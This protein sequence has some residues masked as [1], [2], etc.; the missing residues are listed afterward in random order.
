MFSQTS[1]ALVI[2]SEDPLKAVSRTQNQIPKSMECIIPTQLPTQASHADI[3]D[4]IGDDIDSRAI[5]D[6][7][8]G[9][10]VV[11]DTSFEFSSVSC[12]ATNMTHV[13]RFASK[14]LT[15]SA[16]LLR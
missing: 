15:L 7:S 13:S 1:K 11:F 8:V 5:L 16:F 2:A 10:P 4:D 12:H 6:L 9:E 3:G 14:F